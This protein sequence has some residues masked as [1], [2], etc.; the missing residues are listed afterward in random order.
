MNASSSLLTKKHISPFRSAPDLLAFGIETLVPGLDETI[1]NGHF[2][3]SESGAPQAAAAILFVSTAFERTVLLPAEEDCAT[4]ALDE[5]FGTE[6]VKVAGV[7]VGADES[8]GIGELKNPTDELATT[9]L[10]YLVDALAVGAVLITVERLLNV[11]PGA[12]AVF[13]D[14]VHVQADFVVAVVGAGL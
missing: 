11:E 8:F 10:L 13:P 2:T 12:G 5:V 1:A 4:V 14:G 9:P 6:L 7:A 3:G